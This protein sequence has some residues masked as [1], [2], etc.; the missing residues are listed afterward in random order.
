[1]TKTIIKYYVSCKTYFSKLFTINRLIFLGIFTLLITIF[2]GIN[3]RC[4]NYY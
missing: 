3:K 4:G 1:M 2:L